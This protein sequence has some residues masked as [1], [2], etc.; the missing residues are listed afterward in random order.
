MEKKKTY[1]KPTAL[2]VEIITN[3]LCAA[4][5]CIDID[6]K[7]VRLKEMQSKERSY[8]LKDGDSQNMWDS[9]F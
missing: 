3:D 8:V 9:K 6:L 4:S 2:F 5:T 1:S 7:T